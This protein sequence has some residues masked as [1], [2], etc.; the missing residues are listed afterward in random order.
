MS[1]IPPS[2][3]NADTQA[4][5]C[6]VKKLLQLLCGCKGTAFF[7][8]HKFW[9]GFLQNKCILHGNQFKIVQND[10]EGK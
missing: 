3:I 2:R 6:H 4:W 8:I 5:D 9:N 10:D 1:A 7:D